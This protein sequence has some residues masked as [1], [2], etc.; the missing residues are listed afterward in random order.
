MNQSE[1]ACGVY[2]CVAILRRGVFPSRENRRNAG[3]PRNVLRRSRISVRL[4]SLLSLSKAKKSPDAG[5]A[6]K[7]L[8][9]I[10]VE[11]YDILPKANEKKR[12]K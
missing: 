7:P 10:L 9:F 12:V 2:L 5:A 8:G 4:H 1:V 3:A 11:E 6:A